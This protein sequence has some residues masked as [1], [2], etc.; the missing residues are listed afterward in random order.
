MKTIPVFSS[1][2]EIAL[3][4]PRLMDA[5]ENVLL[6]GRFIMGE[7]VQLFEREMAA[8]LGMKHAIGLNSGTDALVIALKAA[9]I[10]P[11]D[12]VITTAFTFFATAE[13][14]HQVGAIPVFIDIDADTYNL[15]PSLIESAITTRTKAILPVHLFGQA[16]DMKPIMEIAQRY[17]LKVIEDVA[18]ALGADYND[19]MAGTLGDAGCYSFFPTKNLGAYGDAGLIATNDDA[20]AE[21]ARMLRAHGSRKKYYNETFG[22]N[23]RLDEMQAAVLRV[24][25]PHLGEWNEARG[26][27]SAKYNNALCDLPGIT[28]P[29]RQPLGTHVF[30]QY[31]IRV[32]NGWREAVMAQLKSRGIETMIYYPVP[33][34]QLPVYQS[35][36]H[37]NLP[38]SELAA[39]EV[40]SLPIWPLMTAE[41]QDK[42]I[43]AIREIIPTLV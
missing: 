17:N 31:T 1:Q 43:E 22:Y 4:K 35:R 2:D 30:H 23:S 21:T 26:R 40:L 15:N 20:L 16:A 29:A 9:G 25:L 28:I 39:K 6:S 24:K 11:E 10:G 37:V 32:Q 42:V 12:E 14:I 27:I 3:L 19:R 38:V 8:Y 34:H 33:V 7:Q 36:L 18:Q 41:I 5:M 13:G